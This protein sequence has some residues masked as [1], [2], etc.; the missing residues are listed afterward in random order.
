MPPRVLFV[1]IAVVVLPIPRSAVGTVN[2]SPPPSGFNRGFPEPSNSS[3]EVQ[4]LL[5]G[6]A[7]PLHRRPDTY[8]KP[9]ERRR[10]GYM[11]LKDQSKALST[12]HVLKG[13]IKLLAERF[14]RYLSY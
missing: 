11:L 8:R 12:L 14:V 6:I 1:Y 3:Y 2:L 4:L 7:P 10:L 5:L 9:E 13:I